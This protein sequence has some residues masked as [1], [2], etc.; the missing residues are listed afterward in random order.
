MSDEKLRELE[1]RIVE[2]IRAES[3]GAELGDDRPLT[4]AD[5]AAV[6]GISERSLREKRLHGEIPHFYIGR[7]P[8][9]TIGILRREI[10]ARME[11]VSA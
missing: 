11:A 8:R 3:I 10:R 6:L 4:E 7:S 1:D 9:Y 5:A 2:R